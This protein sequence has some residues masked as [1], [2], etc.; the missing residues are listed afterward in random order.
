MPMAC[1]GRI[2]ARGVAG[3]LMAALTL[4]VSVQ[5]QQVPGGKREPI[6]EVLG[7]PV[8]RDSIRAGMGFPVRDELHRLFT[9]PILEKYRKEHQAEIEPTEG[10]IVAVAAFFDRKHRERLGDSEAGLRNDLG[11]VEKQLKQEGLAKEKRRQLELEKLSLQARLNPPG[12]PFA[13]FMLG[14]WKFQ[15]HLHDHFGG[16]RILWQQGGI[17]AFDAYLKWLQSREKAGDFIITDS[18]LRDK[19]Y[20]YWT[21]TN[22][23]AFLTGDKERIKR[24]L[25]E[26][27]WMPGARARD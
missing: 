17:E 20:E 11:A 21:K 16:G 2:L 19:Y 4:A 5:G 27:E 7:Q 8:F 10:E 1:E 18:V 14:N 26:P 9:T 6:G 15:K 24:E 23:G 13:M 25:L 3:C 22:H 12:R